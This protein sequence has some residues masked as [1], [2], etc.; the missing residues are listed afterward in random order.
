MALVWSQVPYFTD[1][2][3]HFFLRKI[4]SKIQVHLILKI[5]IKCPLFDLKFPPVLK[6]P[7]IRCRGK[8]ISIWQHWI[9]LEAAVHRC[10][11]YELQRFTSLLTLSPSCPAIPNPE[12]LSS[13]WCIIAVYGASEL[14]LKMICVICNSTTFLLVASFV[15]EKN[16]RYS[17]DAGY[18]LKVIAY[19]EEQG[20]R[21]AERH[22]SPPPMKKTIRDWWASKE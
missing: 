8:P 10:D 17:Y 2:K 15:M 16:K 14:E 1:Y 13:L 4:A 3:T 12:H 20:N 21:A 9:Q 6:W 18:K 19:A 11:E 22:F 5:N 7:Y